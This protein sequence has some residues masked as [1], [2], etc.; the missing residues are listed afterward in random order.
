MV[1]TSRSPGDL[2]ATRI[3]NTIVISGF[4]YIYSLFQLARG[5]YVFKEI[6]LFLEQQ[7]RSENFISKNF[8][9][10]MKF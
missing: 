5:Q 6:R 9:I 3:G 8:A 2:S 7:Y 10:S 1:V 4:L